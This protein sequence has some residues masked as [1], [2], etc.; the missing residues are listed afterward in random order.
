MLLVRQV[1]FIKE[2]AYRFEIVATRDPDAENSNQPITPSSWIYHAPSQ[3][4]RLLLQND[5]MIHHS[6]YTS[7]ICAPDLQKAKS[8]T[9]H[10]DN[11]HK[12]EKL[13]S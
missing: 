10:L 12:V 5:A 7:Q 13:A 11:S 8:Y 6:E 3:N 1:G 9:Q 2:F 4:N